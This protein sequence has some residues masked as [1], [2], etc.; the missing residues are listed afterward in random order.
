MHNH[1]E[2]NVNHVPKELKL[3]LEIM[4][5]GS[6]EELRTIDKD[7]FINIDWDKFLELAFHHRVYSFIYPKMKE[8]DK[9]L[10]PAHVLQTLHQYFKMNTF[11]MLYLSAEMEK[12]SKLFSENQIRLL[13]LKGPVLAADLYG[14]ISLRASKDLDVLVPIGDLERVH[15]L[16]LKQGYVKEED[17]STVLNEWKWR[18]HHV[19]YSHPEKGIELEI[20]WRLHP[21]PCKEP[22]FN[23]LWE[24]RRVSSIT[25]YPVYFLGREDLFSFLVVHGTRHGWSRLRWLTD[26]DQIV[27]QGLDWKSLSK[28]LKKYQCMHLAG[29]ALT[30]SSQLLGTPMAGDMLALALRKYSGELAQSAIFYLENMVNLHTDPVPEEASRY[31]GRYLF[32]LKT[33]SQK[34]L[35]ILSFLYPYPEDA[36]IL[37]LP[38]QLH[39]LYFPLRPILWIWRKTR[40][41]ALS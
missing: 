25:S 33:N 35:F 21:G 31:H 15:T 2:L 16:L 20:H 39:L 14:D 13:F 32:L 12:I 19:T 37:P 41:H 8:M 5:R 10:I 18:R 9:G 7:W 28:L 34:F 6:A 22:R 27:R 40:K 1:Y 38:K 29:Q 36:E 24:R 23:E 3:Q 30:L 17:F 26:I 4:G 11:Q